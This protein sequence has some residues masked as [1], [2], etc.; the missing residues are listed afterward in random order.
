MYLLTVAFDGQVSVLPKQVVVATT[1]ADDE[2]DSLIRVLGQMDSQQRTDCADW[3][4]YTRRG[5]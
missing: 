1:F 4:V 2:L 5:L 3:K